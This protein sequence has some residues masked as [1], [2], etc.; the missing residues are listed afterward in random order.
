MCVECGEGAR[1]GIADEAVSGRGVYILFESLM[2]RIRPTL[3][4]KVPIYSLRDNVVVNCKLC[5]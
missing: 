5:T 3:T 2:I 4:Y 1:E